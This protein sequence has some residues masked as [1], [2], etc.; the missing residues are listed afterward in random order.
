M[1]E[2]KSTANVSPNLSFDLENNCTVKFNFQA[3]SR[4]VI[5]AYQDGKAITGAFNVEQITEL[6][7]ILTA[8]LDKRK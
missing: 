5:I 3:D 1:L 2:S 7:D 8:Y 4:V 6:R